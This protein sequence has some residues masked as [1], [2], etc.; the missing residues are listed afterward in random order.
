MKSESTGQKFLRLRNEAGLTQKQLHELSGVSVG[1]IWNIENGKGKQY[2]STIY[3]LETAL[4]KAIDVIDP[5][6]L[7]RLAVLIYSA[8]VYD[9]INVLGVKGMPTKPQVKH[10]S[11]KA[12][13]RFLSGNKAESDMLHEYI[14]TSNLCEL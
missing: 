12:A 4:L 3:R 10:K 9:S 2:A 13:S 11:I 5:S 1:T 6:E 14:Q 8:F 7:E